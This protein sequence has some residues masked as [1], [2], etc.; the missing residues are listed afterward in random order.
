AMFFFGARAGEGA[1][2]VAVVM[3][4]GEGAELEEVPDTVVLEFQLRAAGN[5]ARKQR[6]TDVR[7]GAQF[8]EQLD[9][10]GEQFA[11]AP[12]QFAREKM[13]VAVEE[14]SDIFIRDRDFVLLENADD[15]PEV[16]HAGDLD[17]V[18]VI[19]DAVAFLKRDNERV[20]AG[21]AGVDERTVNIEKQKALGHYRFWRAPRCRRPNIWDTTARVPPNI[22]A[23]GCASSARRPCCRGTQQGQ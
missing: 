6:E 3:I 1:E 15:D 10:A 21:A 22:T 4:V 5:V 7:T 19:V 12:R 9:H 11:F 2:L 8:L 23:R 14:R 18:Q 16:G 17:V 20:H 13:G